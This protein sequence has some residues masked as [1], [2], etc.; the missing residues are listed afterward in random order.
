MHWSSLIL[1]SHLRY[2]DDVLDLLEKF[3][4][5]SISISFTIFLASD[6]NM[7]IIM[8]CVCVCGI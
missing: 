7:D 4:Y 8:A 1:I 6:F 2:I 3:E 5:M